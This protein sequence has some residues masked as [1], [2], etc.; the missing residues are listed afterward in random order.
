MLFLTADIG[1][2]NSRF[3]LVRI[4]AASCGTAVGTGQA[5]GF[6]D[7][8]DT[9][10]GPAFSSIHLESSV[11]L[12]TAGAASFAELLTRLKEEAPHIGDIAVD[13]AAF[14]LAGPVERGG[15]YC[16]PPNVG[17]AAH[18]EDVSAAVATRRALFL[19]DFVA[20]A[21]ACLYP[22][23]LT[24]RTIHE[25]RAVAGS[26]VAV[27][28]AGTG[29][30][31]CLLLP[32]GMPLPSEGGHGLFPFAGE[33]E[34]RFADFAVR[35][36]GRELIGDTVVSGMGLRLLHAFHTGEWLEPAQVAQRLH[37]QHPVECWFARFYGRVCRNYVLDTLAL[38]GLFICGGVAGQNPN[39]LENS[40]F[41]AEFHRSDAYRP[42]LEQIPL[43]LVTSRDA[44][45]YGAALYALHV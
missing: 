20:Q 1:G 36:A 40:E 11:W 7:A 34:F 26:P 38:G 3:G 15:S 2:T 44:A 19:N 9:A 42:L 13:A 29:L 17:W 25:G 37:A 27:M 14:A 24:L 32:G 23:V 4:E 8:C 41:L 12:P 35:H 43:R 39:L 5:A 33:E 30:G 18:I 31:K 21:M 6:G 22:D 10:F 45:L 16:R 28:G